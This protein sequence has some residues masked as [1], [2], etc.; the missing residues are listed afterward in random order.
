LAAALIGRF[1]S[2]V[3]DATICRYRDPRISPRNRQSWRDGVIAGSVSHQP[4]R[5]AARC[6]GLASCLLVLQY[7]IHPFCRAVGRAI[8]FLICV[9]GASHF[10]RR[11]RGGVVF[12]EI[13]SRGRAFRSNGVTAAFASS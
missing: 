2:T 12:A 3:H 8:T 10:R 7:D 6:A 13:I 4:R 11:L 9:L 5:W 1:W